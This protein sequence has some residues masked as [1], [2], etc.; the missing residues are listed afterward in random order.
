MSS[1]KVSPHRPERPAAN[2][3][4]ADTFA[5]SELVEGLFRLVRGNE[6]RRLR[7]LPGLAFSAY[8]L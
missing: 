3:L 4:L 2:E 6:A 7:G 1:R 8:A 5:A